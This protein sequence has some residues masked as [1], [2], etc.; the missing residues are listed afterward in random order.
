[1]EGGW[2][3]PSQ[4]VFQGKIQVKDPVLK[5]IIYPCLLHTHLEK[6]QSHLQ[7]SGTILDEPWSLGYSEKVGETHC[8]LLLLSP[9]ETALAVRSLADPPAA[10]LGAMH[11][12]WRSLGLPQEFQQRMF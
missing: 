2:A 9:D 8:L 3:C 5:R 4:T 7:N 6:T 10:A 11:G 12:A 1:M